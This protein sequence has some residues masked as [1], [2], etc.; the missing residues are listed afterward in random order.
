MANAGLRDDEAIKK[1]IERAK[2]VQKGMR[3]VACTRKTPPNNKPLFAHFYLFIFTDK[4]GVC[5]V[6]IEAL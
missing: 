3:P 2:F 1:C 6:E 5:N 4:V